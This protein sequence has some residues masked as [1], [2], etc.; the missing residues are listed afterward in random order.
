LGA[1][2][3]WRGRELDRLPPSALRLLFVLGSEEDRRGVL[4]MLHDSEGPRR[5]A[6]A[7]AVA[8][9]RDALDALLEAAHS[10]SAMF[11][12]VAQAVTAFRPSADGFLALAEVPAADPAQRRERLLA[13]SQELSHSELTRAA[14]A[15][16]DPSLREAMLTRLLREPL[17]SQRVPGSE[18]TFKPEVIAGILTLCRTRMELGQPAGAL[19]AL[20]ALG[21]AADQVNP[22]YLNELRVRLLLWLNRLDEASKVEVGPEVW[23]EGLDLCVTLEHAPKVADAIEARFAGRLSADDTAKLAVMRSRIGLDRSVVP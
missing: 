1:L 17:A 7:T 2:Q 4:A 22:A 18:R 11:P 12:L 5:W 21:G 6:A 9:V 23:L 10:D 16:K 3:A 13:L 8:P 20:D 19:A 14:R 15:T